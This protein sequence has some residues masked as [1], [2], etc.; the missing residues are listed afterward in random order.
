MADTSAKRGE[1][2]GFVPSGGAW[3]PHSARAKSVGEFVPALMRPAF[4]KYG[5][6]AAAIL[7]D[8]AAIAGTELAAF[9]AP[10]RLKWPRKASSDTDGG[11][12]G[13]TL[14]LRVDGP[15]ALEVE[16]LRPR[17][18]ERIN[19]SFGY[20]AVAD[21]RV[22]QAPLLRRDAPKKP[23]MPPQPANMAVFAGLK[24]D[25]VKEALARI[26]AGIEATHQRSTP[27]SPRH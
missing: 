3:R 8:W 10:E 2:Q 6:P 4:E 17:L 27:I 26:A 25:R 20:R 7:T 19:A 23:A 18:I 14:I 15:R 5:F 22:L 16:H 9:T 21:I 13:A 24:E 12:Q 11:G 1:R